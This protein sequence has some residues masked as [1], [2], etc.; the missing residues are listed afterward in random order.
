MPAPGLRAPAVLFATPGQWG[1]TLGIGLMA[2]LL[3]LPLYWDVSLWVGA[4]VLLMA[5]A[6]VHMQFAARYIVPLP[7]VA[8][9]FGAFQLVVA[10][11]WASYYRMSPEMEIGARLPTYLAYAAPVALV[12]AAGWLLPSLGMRPRRPAPAAFA[13][14]P[15]LLR[16]LDWLLLASFGAFA[17]MH[18]ASFGP[19]NFP[20]RLLAQFRFVAAIAWMLL[21]APGWRR[22][23]GLVLGAEAFLSFASAAV[24]DLYLWGL[25]VF[26]IY[27]FRWRPRPRIVATCMAL[28]MAGALVSEYAKTELRAV[29]WYGEPVPILDNSARNTH[30]GRA[31]IFT[32]YLAE[33]TEKMFTGEL[34]REAGTH[35]AERF[36]QGWIV[37]RVM[38]QVPDH[39][40]YAKGETLQGAVV[41]ALSVRVLFP[42]KYR[43]G[44]QEAM[45]RFAGLEMTSSTSMNLGY[46]GEMYANF[47]YVG[48]ILAVFV[49][50][51]AFGLPFR[52]LARR[53]ERQPLWWAILPLV[54]H[55]GLKAEEGVGEVV[56]WTVKA[57]IMS[58]VVVMMMPELRARLRRLPRR[59][60]AR[61]PMG[62]AE[63]S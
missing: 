47:G 41:N 33:G 36:N 45:A 31:T 53:A 4:G 51:L 30:L 56:N 5:A 63:Q 49:Y 13:A 10:A 43:A 44:G 18:V 23:V 8:F 39:E 62:A 7:H 9:F 6:L 32:Y 26:V 54:L 46:A 55:W 20:M 22:R 34:F 15:R 52:W 11:W 16:E 27:L 61:R 60:P 14:D 3:L 38:V 48:G 29:T 24:H 40:P 57:V 37:N 28:G 42:N 1:L 12:F 21:G 50:G 35:F 2:A 59:L 19:L 58:A 17:A 25:S